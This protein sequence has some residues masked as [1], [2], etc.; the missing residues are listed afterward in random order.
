MPTFSVQTFSI[1]RDGDVVEMHKVRPKQIGGVSVG[2]RADISSL[3]YYREIIKH[4]SEKPG[5]FYVENEP[6]KQI[7]TDVKTVTITYDYE[8]MPLSKI[9]FTLLNQNR[10]RLQI[11]IGSGLRYDFADGTG[12]VQTRDQ[13]DT[14]NINAIATNALIAHKNA[15]TDPAIAFRDEENVTHMMTPIQAM[16]FGQAV[17]A[18]ITDLYQKKWAIADEIRAIGSSVDAAEYD[19]SYKWRR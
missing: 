6:L 9:Q 3:G 18:H 13:T 2:R 19:L 11:E 5:Q 15:V 14:G 16:A 10:R 1:V 7:N 12:T 8:L 17:A 4:A